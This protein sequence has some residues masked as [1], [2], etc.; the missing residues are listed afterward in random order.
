[1]KTDLPIP[2]DA[3][4]EDSASE[5]MLRA[6]AAERPA[7]PL[8]TCLLPA[9]NEEGNILSMLDTLHTLMNDLGLS[10]G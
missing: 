6:R 9:F 5:F 3:P 1:M 7:D 4:P 8:I 2:M 10:H